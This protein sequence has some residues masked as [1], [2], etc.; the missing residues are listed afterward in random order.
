MIDLNGTENLQNSS[1]SIYD[2]NGHLRLK[3][4]INGEK[5]EIFIDMFE[6]GYYVA[7]ISNSRYSVTKKFLKL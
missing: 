3:R 1:I 4:S 6:E 5:T 2:M 7:K